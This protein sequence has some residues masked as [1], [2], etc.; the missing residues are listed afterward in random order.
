[1]LARVHLHEYMHAYKMGFKAHE[2]GMSVGGNPFDDDE[3]AVKH[4][5]WI[6]G[7]NDANSNQPSQHPDFPIYRILP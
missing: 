5:A 3:E 2:S 6:E 4:T 7:W 1:M